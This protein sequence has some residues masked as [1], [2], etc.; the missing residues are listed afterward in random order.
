MFSFCISRFTDYTRK[1]LR[2]NKRMLPYQ[3]LKTCDGASLG[4]R[5]LPNLKEQSILSLIII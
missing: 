5:C 1:N 4:L 2:R 3:Y